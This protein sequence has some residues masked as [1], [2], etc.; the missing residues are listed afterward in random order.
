MEMR[1]I[2][3]RGVTP[4]LDP[5][6]ID[7]SAD[8]F[9]ARYGG[10]IEESI[11]IVKLDSG[12]L[13]YRS[14]SGPTD[15]KH[16]EFFSSF[17]KIATDIGIKVYAMLTTYSD[18]YF[19]RD[20]KYSAMKS[21][22]TEK[23]TNYF[24]CPT[25]ESYSAYLVELVKEILK[26]GVSGIALIDL[27][28]PRKE[29]CFCP[30][31]RNEFS[32]LAGIERDFMLENLTRDIDLYD[33]WMDRRT[34]H[35]E[36]IVKRIKD[37]ILDQGS[38]VQVFTEIYLDSETGFVEGARTHF[39][40]DVQ[41]LAEI[42]DQL[43]LHLFPLTPLLPELETPSYTSLL[44]ALDFTTDLK[45]RGN[46][47]SLMFWGSTEEDGIRTLEKLKNDLKANGIWVLPQYPQHYKERR[48]IQLGW[49][50]D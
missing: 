17:S 28:F 35:I 4:I 9:L 6:F 41:K 13:L 34:E 19:A 8:E 11:I 50:E 40:Q 33:Q 45:A 43:I 44:E 31:C 23:P 1:E 46:E 48:E 47:Y 37:E 2:L 32:K 29:Y 25:H 5:Y 16:S 10:Y 21:G 24:V 42:S 22:V 3:S 30:N 15:E 26:F 36:S 27:L 39:G 12:K 7:S 14:A 18:T 49:A 38:D 20:K